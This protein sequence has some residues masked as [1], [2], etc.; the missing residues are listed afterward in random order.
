MA[1]SRQLLLRLIKDKEKYYTNLVSNVT[2]QLQS[3]TMQIVNTKKCVVFDETA[4]L[5]FFL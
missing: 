1:K 3:S 2:E 4:M 5:L